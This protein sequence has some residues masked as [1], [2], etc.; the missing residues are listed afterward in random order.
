MFEINRYIIAD[1]VNEAIN[2]GI[3]FYKAKPTLKN[4]IKMRD[5]YILPEDE[6]PFKKYGHHGRIIFDGLDSLNINVETFIDERKKLINECV[7]EFV[8]IL[9]EYPDSDYLFPLLPDCTPFLS[10]CDR[11]EDTN[12]TSRFMVHTDLIANTNIGIFEFYCIILQRMR[13]VEE[14]LQNGERVLTIRDVFFMNPEERI[15]YDVQP[16]R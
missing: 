16:E 4:L 11:D 15:K 7:N 6:L 1:F 3:D 10:V 2:Q 14:V 12:F 5:N 13:E 8:N 9:K